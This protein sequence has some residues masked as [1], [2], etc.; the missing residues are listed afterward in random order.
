MA[1]ESSQPTVFLS[2]A[3]DDRVKAQQLAAAFERQQKR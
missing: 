2:Y 3:H 1:S